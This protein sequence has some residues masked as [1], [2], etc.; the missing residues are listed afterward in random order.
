MASGFGLCRSGSAACRHPLA[1]QSFIASPTVVF[2]HSLSMLRNAV[3]TCQCA[4]RGSCRSSGR[5]Q[6]R[7]AVRDGAGPDDEDAHKGQ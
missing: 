2:M 6:Q 3:N 7:H 4:A 1:C 5:R